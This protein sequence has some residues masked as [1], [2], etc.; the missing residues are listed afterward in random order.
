MGS[1]YADRRKK[2]STNN[3]RSKYLIEFPCKWQR[4]FFRR[5]FANFVIFRWQLIFAVIHLL[6]NERWRAWW[7]VIIII[8]GHFGR[9][10]SMFFLRISL[11]ASSVQTNAIKRKH[12]RKKRG[13]EKEVTLAKAQPVLQLTIEQRSKNPFG[14]HNYWSAVGLVSN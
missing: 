1:C 13:G 7:T 11:S 10:A 14:T 3:F 12:I 4:P 2:I 8:I 5:F 9:N 6:P